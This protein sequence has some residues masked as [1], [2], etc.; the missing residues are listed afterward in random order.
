MK[1]L[2]HMDEPFGMERTVCVLYDYQNAGVKITSEIRRV[3]PHVVG[4]KTSSF[5]NRW[6]TFMV[7]HLT[8]SV[9]S[10]LTFK[11]K[12]PKKESHKGLV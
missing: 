2:G 3:R 8:V 4:V 5:L 9:C 1:D 12:R 10:V 7:S 11:K 6:T